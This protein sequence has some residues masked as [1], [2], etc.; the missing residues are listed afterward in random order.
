MSNIWYTYGGSDSL[1]RVKEIP[2][3]NRRRDPEPPK[4]TAEQIRER[5]KREEEERKARIRAKAAETA[6]KLDKSGAS[7]KWGDLSLR[8]ID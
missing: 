3:A 7:K 5:L 6:K 4:E 8:R 1:E 2:M